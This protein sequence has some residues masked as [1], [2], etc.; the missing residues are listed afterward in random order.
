MG[1]PRDQHYT[2][3]DHFWR[4]QRKFREILKGNTISRVYGLGNPH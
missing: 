4:M 1:P 2:K 3:M